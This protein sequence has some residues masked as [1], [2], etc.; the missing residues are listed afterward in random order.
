MI[1]K[2]EIINFESHAHTI[3]DNFSDGLNIIWGDINCGKSSIVRALKLVWYNEFD[4]AS[5]RIG[6]DTC[7]VILTTDK[8]KVTV[9]KGEGINRWII[10]S[11]GKIEEF[12][13][14]GKGILP[15]VQEI[16]GISP[17]DVGDIG[18]KIN[19]MNQLD[20]HF[21]MAQIGNKDSSGSLRAQIIDEISGLI[22]VEELIKDI[23]LDNTR[24]SKEIK[25]V[26]KT[27]KE[28]QKNIHDKEKIEEEKKILSF[29][30]EN[31]TKCESNDRIINECQLL[32][33]KVEQTKQKI[34]DL[35]KF[36]AITFD[37]NVIDIQMYEKY[38]K[39]LEKIYELPQLP[40]IDFNKFNSLNEM[41]SFYLN[42]K[43]IKIPCKIDLQDVDFKRFNQIEGSILNRYEVLK[44]GLESELVE[45]IEV[46][47]NTIREE[48]EK[49]MKEVK[50][51]P[52]TKEPID[53]RCKKIKF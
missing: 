9:V 51:C 33:K 50:I 8:G 7:S 42:S 43:K 52:L 6:S 48:L 32:L 14:H 49:E 28:V 1:R 40:S 11:N 24:L 27:I 44:S 35:P 18:L 39:I 47:M 38:S 34:V 37:F 3:L 31:Q 53:E 5:I 20:G 19:V 25:Q 17:I 10:E 29:I 41:H 16:T 2:L 23:S 45:N 26:E 46:E 15:Q 4:K 12:N 36:I 30:E 13:N 21:L 22:G